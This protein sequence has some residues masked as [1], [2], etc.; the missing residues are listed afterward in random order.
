MPKSTYH[1]S[2]AALDD[3]KRIYQFGKNKFGETQADQYLS[4]LFKCFD[5]IQKS[6]YSFESVE[7]IQPGFRRCVCGVDSIYFKIDKKEIYISTIIGRQ[8]LRF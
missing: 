4:D 5:R 6:P 7:H 2:H 8:E 3:L 1:L